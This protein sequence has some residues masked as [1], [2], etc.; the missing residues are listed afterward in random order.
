MDMAV[1]RPALAVGDSVPQT[2]RLGLAVAPAQQLLGAVA[3]EDRPAV[4]LR[5]DLEGDPRREVRLDD[6]GDHVRAI[7]A[8]DAVGAVTRIQ[9]IVAGPTDERIRAIPA[10]RIAWRD[11][12]ARMVAA[13]Q[14]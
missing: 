8:V 12:I 2:D 11:G 14:S 3:V 13:N 9:R 4:D 5:E 6:A 7:T 1:Q 10:T